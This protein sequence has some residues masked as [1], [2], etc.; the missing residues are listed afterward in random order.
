MVSK[1]Q[2]I[3]S[4]IVLAFCCVICACKKEEETHVVG[5]EQI[6]DLSVSSYKSAKIE[7]A[8]SDDD[9]I[10]YNKK[11]EVIKNEQGSIYSLEIK[12][13]ADD[14]YSSSMYKISN[15]SGLLNKEET[16]K[17]FPKGSQFNQD[18]ISE[19][20]MENNKITFKV[21]KSNIMSVFGLEI[22][23][24]SKISDDGIAIEMTIKNDRVETYR[25]MYTG[26]DGIVALIIGEFVY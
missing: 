4:L 1:F 26:I 10:V 9:F 17:L 12:E 23:D 16:S 11:I 21:D 6:L 3:I 25:Y 20:K 2:K 13:L 22:Q 15:S 7:I 18:K 19:Y 5:I 14:L 8:L 24:I